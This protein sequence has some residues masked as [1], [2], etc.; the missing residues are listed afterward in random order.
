MAN[1]LRN[2]KCSCK[3]FVHL[4]FSELK[5]TSNIYIHII[6]NILYKMPNKNKM[7]VNTHLLKSLIMFV[8]NSFSF[9]VKNKM[10]T[11]M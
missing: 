11:N 9:Y 3:V 5:A 1:C 6:S 8:K 2:N 10:N 7:A 4:C